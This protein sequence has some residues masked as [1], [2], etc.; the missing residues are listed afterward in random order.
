ML[1]NMS[2]FVC[3]TK[4]DDFDAVLPFIIYACTGTGATRQKQKKAVTHEVP[5]QM[6]A[7]AQRVRGC[8]SAWFLPLFMVSTTFLSASNIRE[9]KFL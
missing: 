9:L 8:Q 1:K 3:L 5:P 4:T 7:E 6:R 2:F